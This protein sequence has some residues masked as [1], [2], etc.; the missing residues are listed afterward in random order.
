[1]DLKAKIPYFSQKP[2]FEGFLNL[3]LFLLILA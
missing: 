3:I 1:M 2:V